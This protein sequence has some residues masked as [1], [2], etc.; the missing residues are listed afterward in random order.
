M[1]IY[2]INGAQYS[3]DNSGYGSVFSFIQQLNLPF[4]SQNEPFAWKF[5]QFM[6]FHL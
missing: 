1:V 4:D 5:A 2:S 3:S 6:K